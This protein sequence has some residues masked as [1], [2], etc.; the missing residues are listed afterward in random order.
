[1][2]ADIALR[3]FCPDGDEARPVDSLTA[4]EQQQKAEF[5]QRALVQQHVR[6]MRAPEAHAVGEVLAHWACHP[7]VLA[8][9]A[10]QLGWPSVGW[11]VTYA[12]E[13]QPLLLRLFNAMLAGRG[14]HLAATLRTLVR[15]GAAT[16]AAAA[17]LRKCRD[18]GGHTCAEHT[19]W[20]RTSQG[21]P[22]TAAAVQ[23]ADTPTAES[24]ATCTC[25]W[26]GSAQA[27]ARACRAHARSCRATSATA[28]A[29]QLHALAGAASQVADCKT[30]ARPGL[31]KRSDA[32]E[33]QHSAALQLQWLRLVARGL[34]KCAR[35]EATV[36]E[37]CAGAAALAR[38]QHGKF[39]AKL[40][41]ASKP[42]CSA[43]AHSRQASAKASLS[44]LPGLSA[45]ASSLR[46][47]Q[48]EQ[49][50]QLPALEAA[51]V[52]SVCFC[53]LCGTA[54]CARHS[55]PARSE[56]QPLCTPWGAQ[57]EPQSP[58]GGAVEDLL[59]ARPCGAE[60]YMHD[61]EE[62]QSVDGRGAH[63]SQCS[64]ADEWLSQRCLLQMT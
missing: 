8:A 54:N 18:A 34:G 62:A 43:G 60:C 25:R 6:G 40:N 12:L 23:D 35:T 14:A 53:V 10:A 2:Q 9:M 3:L 26:H 36:L 42:A 55:R 57:R 13:S 1:M 41:I 46:A 24:A 52:R 4:D 5:E 49:N 37:E 15:A 44:Q 45:G 30:A 27:R 39:A 20:G 31:R 19:D 17:L 56:A 51:P 11:V 58:L 48:S 63:W 7:Q 50:V 47:E 33:L 16:D 28:R 38:R 29:Q 61:R 64:V 59:P 32:S 21:S 22:V